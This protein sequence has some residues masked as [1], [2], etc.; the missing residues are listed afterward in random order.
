MLVITMSKLVPAGAPLDVSVTWS[1][2][3]F[4]LEL[5]VE[6]ELELAGHQ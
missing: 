6:L 2:L 4:L 3:F 5:Q 1:L